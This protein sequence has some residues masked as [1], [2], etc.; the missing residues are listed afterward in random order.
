MKVNS[1]HLYLGD[2]RRHSNPHMSESVL[3]GLSRR[4]GQ[5]DRQARDELVTTHL[6]LVVRLAWKY[7]PD[8]D[9]ELGD[10]IGAGNIGLV[11]AAELYQSEKCPVF[12]GYAVWWIHRMIRNFI[13]KD[14]HVMRLPDKAIRLISQIS[15]VKDSY[16]AQFAR[17]PNTEEICAAT[18]ATAQ[19]VDKLLHRALNPLS[20]DKPFSD[21]SPY[22]WSDM[23]ADSQAEDIDARLACESDRHLLEHL[24][25]DLKDKEQCVLRLFYGLDGK[26]THTLAEIGRKLDITRERA[27]QIR[28]SALE[29]LRHPSRRHLIETLLSG[30][31]H[32]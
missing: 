22:S 6:Y 32:Y 10:L 16:F 18:G 19:E 25:C 17:N 30:E 5:G 31:S 3:A 4:I 20:L 13:N 23:L 26:K 2:A 29:R 24:I 28:D 1:V 14:T 9:V 15:M 21:Q 7:H 8:R 12:A 27:R 11:R